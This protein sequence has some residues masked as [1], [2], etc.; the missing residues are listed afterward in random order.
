MD[1]FGTIIMKVV[2]KILDTV[3]IS[4]SEKQIL[5]RIARKKTAKKRVVERAQIILKCAEGKTNREVA[6]LLNLNV[7][8]VR[9]WRKRFEAQ[10]LHGLAEKTKL[11][12]P[13]TYTPDTCL[14]ILQKIEESPPE[15]EKVWSKKLLAQEFGLSENIIGN[16]LRNEDVQLQ[17]RAR[18]IDTDK[19]FTAKSANVIGLYLN[20]P[21]KALVICVDKNPNIQKLEKQTGYVEIYNQKLAAGLKNDCKKYGTLNLLTALQ[22]ATKQVRS[23]LMQEKNRISF[24]SFLDKILKD[25]CPDQ[26]IHII[27]EYHATYEKDNEWFMQHPHV[28][29]HFTSTAGGWLSQVEIWLGLLV[30]KHL[31]KESVCNID[32]LKIAIQDFTDAYHANANP[33]IWKQGE[34]KESQLKNMIINEPQFNTR[35]RQSL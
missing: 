35:S 29:F 5:E 33:F 19:D 18:C 25:T 7:E 27:L 13:K 26:E 3:K 24:Q 20:P 22:T 10:G 21:E 8:T 30:G 9:T 6:T 28:F 11:I 14:Q 15:G 31:R 4:D 16:I 1:I 32:A 23:K 12:K 17:K 34:I 2:L